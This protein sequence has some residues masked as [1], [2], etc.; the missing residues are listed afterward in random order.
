MA[1]LSLSYYKND[2]VI[3]E[4]AVTYLKNVQLEDG[5]WRAV[6]FIKPKTN[7]PYKSITITTAYVLKALISFEKNGI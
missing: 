6:D 1:L 5:S 2:N 4:E 7:E 3:I